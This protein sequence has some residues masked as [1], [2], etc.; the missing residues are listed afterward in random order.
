MQASVTRRVREALL[1]LLEESPPPVP[2]ARILAGMLI[3]SDS[4]LVFEQVLET[5]TRI[6]REVIRS[7]TAP[8]PGAQ[9]VF[10]FSMDDQL[11]LDNGK[12][13]LVADASITQI[14]QRIRVIPTELEA[15][16]R[17]IEERYE[18][19]AAEE[20]YR[21][22]RQAEDELARLNALVEEMK[23]LRIPHEKMTVREMEERRRA[24]VKTA[25]A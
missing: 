10:G 11:E 18:L 7:R 8:P 3:A 1:T 23:A 6:A 5:W 21:L 15:A 14:Q 24:A 19:K 13:V 25:P 9:M 17:A 20:I 4:G 16:K 2:D 12:K 22:E